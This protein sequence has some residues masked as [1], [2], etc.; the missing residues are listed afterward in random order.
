V[1]ERIF[2]PR[3]IAVVGASRD[4]AKVGNVILRNIASTFTGRIYPVNDKADSVEGMRAFRRLSDIGE[5]VDL[6][7]VSVPRE[8]AVAVIEEAGSAGAGAQ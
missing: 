6:V 1:L 7:V 5:P 4:R 2:Y 8:E 3:S